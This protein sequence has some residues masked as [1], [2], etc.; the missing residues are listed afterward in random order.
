MEEI[1]A[2]EFSVPQKS[3][4]RSGAVVIALIL[5][6]VIAVFF[7]IIKTGKPMQSA[8]TA[9]SIATPVPMDTSGWQIYTDVYNGFSIKY[10]SDTILYK[11]G[12]TA[13]N[14]L[15]YMPTCWSG[16]SLICIGILS[17]LPN[18]NFQ[19]AGLSITPYSDFKNK[20]TCEG[21]DARIERKIG[22]LSA[23]GGAGEEA[24]TGGNISSGVYYRMWKDN[25]CW[26]FDI[27]VGR[28]I[29]TDYLSNGERLMT[30][31]EV[32]QLIAH[33]SQVL[34]TFEFIP[35]SSQ[36]DTSGWQMY[37]STKYGFTVK[38][39]QGWRIDDNWTIEPLKN[40]PYNLTPLGMVALAAPIEGYPNQHKN[41]DFNIEVWSAPSLDRELLKCAKTEAKLGNITIAGQQT[42]ICFN[43]SASPLFPLELNSWSA[44][45]AIDY[46]DSDRLF[47][48]IGGDRTYYDTWK[49]VLST[50]SLIE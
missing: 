46:G 16:S 41:I 30:Q 42:E 31:A 17:A 10:P 3:I 45:I 34:D 12:D 43:K 36:T 39:P 48:F 44:D 15:G 14:S 21:P 18:T 50:F 22:G 23:F 8:I 26:F 28:N 33:L 11:Q 27:G 47:H 6:A 20:E 40:N 13:M 9:S 5:V 49:T 32:N 2:S 29:N 4:S 24:V 19:G 25:T 35:T 38:Y 1:P 7:V 37:T